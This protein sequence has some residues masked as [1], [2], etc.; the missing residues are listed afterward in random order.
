[1]AASGYSLA[2]GT[3]QEGA[4]TMASRRG[5]GEGSIYQRESDGRWCSTVD[6]GWVD[7]KRKRKVIYGKTRKEVAEKLKVMLRDQQQGLPVATE[8]QTVAQYL[9]TWLESARPKLRAST[10]TRYEQLIRRQIV[11][12]I[13]M[14]QL[15]QLR[16]EEVE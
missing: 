15:A 14:R 8:R 13:G 11:P 1:M 9:A 10:H 5:H 6:L 16:P 4:R 12:T 2:E 7:G 3:A